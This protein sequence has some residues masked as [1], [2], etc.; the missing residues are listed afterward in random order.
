M[1]TQD[2]IAIE[3]AKF[4]HGNQPSGVL[5]GTLI[6]LIVAAVFWNVVPQH[7]TVAWVAAVVT[8]TTVRMGIWRAY[9]ARAFLARASGCALS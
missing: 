1:S 2:L 9:R 5:G 6:V 8:L 3:Q 4:I 7:Y